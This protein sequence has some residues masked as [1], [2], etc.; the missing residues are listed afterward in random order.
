MYSDRS[1]T[2]SHGS[3]PL[4]TISR[5]PTPHGDDYTA[6]LLNQPLNKLN[7]DLLKMANKSA[8]NSRPESTELGHRIDRIDRKDKRKGDQDKMKPSHT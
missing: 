1:R 3:Q 7:K 6:V 2:S 5:K 8:K 4:H